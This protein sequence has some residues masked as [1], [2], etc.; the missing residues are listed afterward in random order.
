METSKQNN[1]APIQ[2]TISC[3][4]CTA[5]L[6]FELNLLLGGHGFTCHACNSVISIAPESTSVLKDT[7]H[8]FLELKNGA[9]T[10]M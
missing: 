9:E 7:L 3:P 8:K 10:R 2:Q 5:P 1:T 6:T 4:C